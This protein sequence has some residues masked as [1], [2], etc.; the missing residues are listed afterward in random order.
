MNLEICL[1][2]VLW[3]TV[4]IYAPAWLCVALTAISL[5]VSFGK[6]SNEK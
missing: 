1:G 2:L 3:A 5:L 6:V 4:F